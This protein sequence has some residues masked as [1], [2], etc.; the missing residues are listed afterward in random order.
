MTTNTV[1]WNP[2][3]HE[4]YGMM[5]GKD[6]FSRDGEKVGSIKEVRHPE[7]E[8]PTSRGQHYFLLDPG[9]FKDWFGGYDEVYLPET[10]VD[11]VNPDRVVLNLRG[12]ATAPS[13]LPEAVDAV[14]KCAS[15]SDR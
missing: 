5:P 14:G 10:A 12:K 15:S 11:R 2:L 7:A 6:V 9:L 8:F 3:S 13:V 4:D 1:V